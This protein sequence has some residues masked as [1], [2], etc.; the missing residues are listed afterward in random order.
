MRPL[1]LSVLALT[2]SCLDARPPPSRPTALALDEVRVDAPAD[3]L[4]PRA[5]RFT[6][7][8]DRPVALTGSDDLYLLT[9][10]V[11]DALRTDAY[12]GTLSATNAAR[13][14][15]ASLAVDPDDPTRVTLSA[16]SALLPETAL[17]VLVPPRVRDLD[18]DPLSL[19]D[20]GTRAAA[21]AYAVSPA[22]RCGP[23]PSLASSP[24]VP[25]AV[26]A[27]YVALDRP[28]LGEP[29]ARLTS[30][31]GSVA[32]DAALSCLDRD[33]ARCVRV[34]P[35]A[36]LARDATYTLTLS[37]LRSRAGSPVES[38]SLTLT[39]DGEVSS[40]RL[41]APVCAAGETRID[42]LCVRATARGVEVRAA[43]T[44]EGVVVLSTRGP[45]G[46]TRGA[47][48]RWGTEHTAR[49]RTL[50]APGAW[51]ITV[52]LLDA[53]GTPRDLAVV[54]RWLAPEPL[55][56]V[57]IG[58]VV[59]R[60]RSGSAQEFVELV[61]D[62]D[63]DVSLAGWALASGTS[64]SALPDDA[65]IAARG[66]LVV[67]GADFDPRGEPRVG[68]PPLAP[69]SALLVLSGSLAGRGLRDSGAD[70]SLVSGDGRVASVAPMGDP[71]RSPRAGASLVRADVDLDERDPAAWTYDLAGGA[72]PG[73][74]DR[75]R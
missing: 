9:G 26:R 36:P 66:R 16:R 73:A 74:P 54:E 50:G 12:Y 42:P 4:L 14:V 17:V 8:F 57:R 47:V 44:S 10:E 31:D 37:G 13:R 59:A 28:S 29:V 64:R 32:A 24:R 69:G 61:N 39:T 45:D 1:P 25:P 71:A 33:G 11:T 3:D 38:L 72:T 68:D 43:S 58:E 65:V 2:A 22:R 49:A 20:A 5:P 30:P 75:M 18:G 21:F 55:P 34:A 51:S 40:P 15:P 60:P 56:A 53:E 6:L 35:R 19:G 27:V 67:V 62:A 41:T 70:L 46:A 63:G 52:A 23:L 7:R 48:S